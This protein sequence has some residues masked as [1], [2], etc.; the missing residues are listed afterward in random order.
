MLINLRFSGWHR[1][2]AT[3]PITLLYQDGTLLND[4][5]TNMSSLQLPEGR[6]MMRDK[7]IT[8]ENL[9]G[10]VVGRTGMSRVIYDLLGEGSE[11]A[12]DPPYYATI[13]R[14]ETHPDF[15]LSETTIQDWRG[16]SHTRTV[17]FYHDGLIIVHDRATGAPEMQ[18]RLIWNLPGNVQPLDQGYALRQSGSP[19]EMRLLFV[20][21]NM[22]SAKQRIDALGAHRSEISVDAQQGKLNTVTVFLLRDWVGAS[23]QITDVDGTANLVVHKGERNTMFPLVNTQP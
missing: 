20:G 16:W 10:L 21:S 18:A 13:E 6:S 1:F 9:N 3:N 8:R 12:Q 11:W 17:A 15:D 4:D 23:T 14:F 5:I 2:K 7:R 22:E 19:A